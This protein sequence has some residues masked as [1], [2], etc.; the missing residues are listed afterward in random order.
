[1]ADSS[2]ESENGHSEV[3]EDS[4]EAGE[5]SDARTD[6]E[7]RDC[8][9]RIRISDE[10]V[11]GS[12]TLFLPSGDEDNDVETDTDDAS[13]NEDSYERIEERTDG[14]WLS[15]HP[16][17][18]GNPWDSELKM[19]DTVTNSSSYPTCPKWQKNGEVDLAKI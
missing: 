10:S 14:Q 17:E 5:P 13:E 18:K 4:G 7:L 6:E 2:T 3:E 8:T 11:E 16:W 15:P 12:D 9:E 19:K 1:M